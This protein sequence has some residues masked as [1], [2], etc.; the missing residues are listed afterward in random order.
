MRDPVGSVPTTTPASRARSLLGRDRGRRR[1][2][3]NQ[4]QQQDEPGLHHWT[5][6]SRTRDMAA[7]YRKALGPR[8]ARRVGLPAHPADAG[9]VTA[10]AH[11]EKSPFSPLP[12]RRR[13]LGLLESSGG[14]SSGRMVHL[15]QRDTCHRAPGHAISPTTE[16]AMRRCPRGAPAF[17]CGGGTNGSASQPPARTDMQKMHRQYLARMPDF[18][19]PVR[20]S[21]N[22]TPACSCRT[23]LRPAPLYI[24][25]SVHY[26]YLPA[27]ISWRYAHIHPMLRLIKIVDRH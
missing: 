3:G 12:T 20:E 27:Y 18:A 1:A 9:E 11:W 26:L 14:P 8:T 13:H 6:S 17:M 5:T 10:P 16:R 24:R 25:P 19:C 4:G 7:G 15:P 22:G 21:S 2:A 23:C